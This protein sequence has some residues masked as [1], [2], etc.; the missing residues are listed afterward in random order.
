MMDSETM[1]LYLETLIQEKTF[2][3]A[4]KK[5]YISQP[6]LSKSIS[7]VEC[8]LKTKLVDR[9]ASPIRLT[10]AGER[11]LY[12][13]RKIRNRYAEMVNELSLVSQLDYGRI[14]IGVHAIMGSFLLP[15]ILPS[16]N[17]K[18]P[19]VKIELI[20][21]NLSL[22]ESDLIENKIDL[23]LGMDPVTNKKLAYKELTRDEWCMIV[24][25]SSSLYQ[26]DKTEVCR[27]PF[28][29][30]TLNNE[31]YVLTSHQSAIR[32]QTD[33]F[34]DKHDINPTIVLESNNIGT[35]AALARQGMGI[36][37]LPKSALLENES[38]KNYTIYDFETKDLMTTYFIAHLKNKSLSASDKAFMESARES[39][40]DSYIL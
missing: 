5:L 10:Y 23:Y 6:Y 8:E 27:F 13:L 1:I 34:F 16:F 11:Y 31:K 33:L 39:L 26:T 15:L 25:Q 22:S 19:G 2:T 18:F 29:I 28:P 30:S 21:Q 40:M 17:S 36:T 32:K 3:Q 37:F 38:F 20:E 7:S 14:R 35:V 24:P 9:N 4:A 12:H